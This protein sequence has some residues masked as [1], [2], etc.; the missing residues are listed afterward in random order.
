MMWPFT[1]AYPERK[2]KDVADKEFDYIVIGGGT[3]GCVIAS[4]LSEDPNATVLLLEKGMVKDAFMGTVPMAS[5][6]PHANDQRA[7]RRSEPIASLANRSIEIFT[8]E[9]LGGAIRVNSMLWTRGIPTGYNDWAEKGHP[10]WSWYKVEPF[11]I[12]AEN[13]QHQPKAPHRGHGGPVRLIQHQPVFE[14]QQYFAHAAE[15][16]RLPVEADGNCPTGPAM[17][18]FN[19]DHV[20]M[21]DGTRGSSYSEYLPKELALA[22][23]ARLTVYTGTI[24][25]KL[26]IDV[27]ARRVTGV[28]IKCMKTQKG[29]FVRARR[30]VVV[31]C[32]GIRSPQLL[33]LSGIGPSEHLEARGVLVKRHLPDVGS[34]LSDHHACPIT[35][36]VPITESYHR[37]L[38][39]PLFGLWQFMLY[40][41]QGTGW[42][43]S[44]N[45]TNHIMVTSSHID[46]DTLT[47]NPD[48]EI[49]FFAN[50]ASE[51]APIG[52]QSIYVVLVRPETT[53]RIELASSNPEDEV[54]LFYNMLESAQDRVSW[55]QIS[56]EELV[57]Y[58]EANSGSSFHIASTCPM[59]PEMDG[60]VV[61]DQLQVYGFDNLRV[62]DASVFPLM[63]ACHTMAPAV[64]IGERCADFI[65]QRWPNSI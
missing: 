29:F 64:M 13:V 10:D 3:T 8:S 42:L 48:I 43:H 28:G 24:A 7:T 1:R 50:T 56:D 15:S 4:R 37:L 47:N 27:E 35:V 34:R 39:N 2:C 53:G 9:S 49:S 31:S 44:P 33:M 19:F 22:R 59:R 63:P 25:T 30:E 20:I 16:L 21:S 60:G 61:N 57:S 12:K 40:A 26:E 11:F 51:Y 32:G 38:A 6:G 55:R 14:A 62:A 18:Y 17:G 58:M 65:Q 46:D 41:F 45:T 36:E 23:E 5:Q 52:Q 54:H